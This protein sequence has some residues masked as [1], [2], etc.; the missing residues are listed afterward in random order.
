[1]SQTALN[2]AKRICKAI[3]DELSGYGIF[4]VEM[5]VKGD[6]VWFSEVTCG[7]TTRHGHD[8][9]AEPL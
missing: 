7:R 2:E 3:T 6:T 5:F 9:F 4:G 8:D 1:M